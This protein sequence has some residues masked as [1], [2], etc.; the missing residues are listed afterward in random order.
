MKKI[1]SL[2][3]ICIFAFSLAACGGKKSD[4]DR[5][6]SDT[7]RLDNASQSTGADTSSGNNSRDNNNSSGNNSNGNSNSN[8]NGRGNNDSSDSDLDLTEFTDT[9]IDALGIVSGRFDPVMND[10]DISPFRLLELSSASLVIGRIAPFGLYENPLMESMK[11]SVGGY[12]ERNGSVV[13]FG[14]DY[15]LKAE[16]VYTNAQAVDDR[17]VISGQ[18]DFATN[19]FT[20]EEYTQRDG[21]M[22]RRTVA[23]GVLLS[24]K[25]VVMQYLCVSF[26]TSEEET[27]GIALFFTSDPDNLKIIR[28]SFPHDV[29]FKYTSIVGKGNTTAEDMA[30]GYDL[31]W[32]IIS[33]LD[34]ASSESY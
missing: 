2:I 11:D 4:N 7:N 26:S 23:E 10:S 32:N 9:F 5:S 21:E 18:V 16:N 25:S 15:L 31:M 22:I 6:A 1:I 28:G 3:L 30:S 24:D 27:D 8:N 17:E 14:T 33:D 12:I 20:W 34:K 19:T 29:D 13:T